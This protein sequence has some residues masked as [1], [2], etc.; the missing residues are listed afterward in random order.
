MKNRELKDFQNVLERF[1]TV[2]GRE[3]AYAIYKNKSIIDGE[4]KILD[5]I[6]R[7]PH[8]DFQNYENERTILCITHSE[9]DE[10]GNPIIEQNR[11]K[12]IDP[13][14]FNKEFEELR[15]KYAEVIADLESA[16]KEFMEFMEKENPLELYKIEFSDLPQD[17]S[18][19]EIEMLKPI[20][21]D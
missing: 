1:S 8:P 5:Q 16:E 7:Q 2:K 12:I 6:K 14:E 15:T 19:S 9:K 11:Y 20:L 17:I 21:K 13:A 10:S 4:M 18:G 3:F